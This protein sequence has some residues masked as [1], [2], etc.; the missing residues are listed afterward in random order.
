M[1][2]FRVLFLM[3]FFCLLTV[4]CFGISMLAYQENYN[5]LYQANLADHHGHLTSQEQK[6]FALHMNS[7]YLRNQFI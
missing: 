1:K 2:A 3:T 7:V 4:G 5:A 6:D